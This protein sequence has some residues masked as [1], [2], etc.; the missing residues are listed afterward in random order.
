MD[1]RD[2]ALELQRLENDAA[3][4]AG[5]RMRLL[6][7]AALMGRGGQAYAREFAEAILSDI[8][9]EIMAATELGIELGAAIE[10]AR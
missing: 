3:E 4:K 2:H 9:D 7:Q 1:L 8:R 6:D 5:L 10:K